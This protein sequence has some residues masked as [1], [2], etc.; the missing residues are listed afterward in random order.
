MIFG[1]RYS[2]YSEQ[3][4]SKDISGFAR[5]KPEFTDKQAQSSNPSMIC[6]VRIGCTGQ[7]LST[8]VD[9]FG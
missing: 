3:R 8:L 6:V 5:I 9:T 2:N 7:T 4:V 1:E